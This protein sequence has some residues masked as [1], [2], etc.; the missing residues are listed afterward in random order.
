VALQ[1]AQEEGI[2]ELENQEDHR[3]ILTHRGTLDALAFWEYQGGSAEKFFNMI[4]STHRKELER[5]DAVILLRTTALYAPGIYEGY[6]QSA[7]R[8]IARE[9]REKAL[10]LETFIHNAWKEHPGFFTIGEKEMHW[11]EKSRLAANILSAHLVPPGKPSCC[12]VNADLHKIRYPGSHQYTVNQQGQI[13]FPGKGKSRIRELETVLP[14]GSWDSLIDIGCAKGMFLLWAWQRYGLKR[15]IGV[16]A[17]K[18]MVA[19]CRKAVNYLDAPATILHGSPGEYYKAFQP[20][21]LVLVLHCYHYLYFGS[22]YGTP[23]NPSHD[24]WFDIFARITSDTLV[25]ANPVKPGDNKI[26]FYRQQGISGEVI[27]RYNAREILKSAQRHFHVKQFPLGEGRPYWVMRKP[28]G[29]M[30]K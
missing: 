18:D 28:Q 10:E 16:E 23:G 19:A 17:A 3:G 20:A 2:D 30:K 22:P 8:P 15:L 21:S 25:F 7:G 11:P 14:H 26:S 1:K 9:S 27:R 13:Q 5:Y 12:E 24:R 4:A 29:T 6:R